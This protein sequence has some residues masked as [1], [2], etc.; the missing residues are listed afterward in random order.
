M[1]IK[2]DAQG[3]INIGDDTSTTSAKHLAI[4]LVALTNATGSLTYAPESSISNAA[5]DPESTLLTWTENGADQSYT[6]N[7]HDLDAFINITYDGVEGLELSDLIQNTYS[8]LIAWLTLRFSQVQTV[9]SLQSAGNFD[10]L[11]DLIQN[12]KSE[13]LSTVSDTGNFDTLQGLIQNSKSELLSAVN[14][15]ADQSDPMESKLVWLAA[16]C[17]M[18]RLDT[19]ALLLLSEK[20]RRQYAGDVS[21]LR[22]EPMISTSLVDNL[23]TINHQGDIDV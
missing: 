17:Q 9:L 2:L 16:R 23:V 14:D 11:Q 10:A 7:N 1:Q 18:K 15:S 20:E 4:Y 3:N 12:S 5:Y 6:M 22:P 8:D 19:L 21:A 13:L